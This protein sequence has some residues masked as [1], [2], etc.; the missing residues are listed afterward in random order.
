M[1]PATCEN[2][3]SIIPSLTAD[4]QLNQSTVS[5]TRSAFN[6]KAVVVGLYGVPG[7]G[8]TFLLNRLKRELGQEH[9]AFYEG[10]E[11]IATVIPGGLDEFQKLDEQEKVYWRQ[12]AIDTIGKKCADSGQ[13]AVVTGHFMFWPEEEEAGWPVYTQNDLQTYTNILYLD[14]PAEVV[15]QR[16]LEDTEKIR[17]STSVTHL[18][19]WQQAE[20]TQL[21]RL[22]REYDILFSLVSPHMLLNKVS[23]LL[24]DFRHH[25]EEY[26]LSQ[27]ESKLDEAIIADQGQ[28][29]TMLVIDADRT[30]AAEDSGALF[31][32]EVSNLRRSRDDECTLKTLF[33][34]PL[35]YSYTAFRQATLL[36]EE[37]A[38][39]QEFDALCQNVASAVTMHPEFVSLL[40]LVAEQEHVGAVVVSCGLRR[41]WEKVLEREGLSKTVK[42]VG[43]GRIADGFVVTAAVKAALV[44][45]SRDTHKMYVWAF[46]DSPLDLDMLSKA[47]EA[48]VV[49]GEEQTRSKTMDAALMNAIDN[50]GLRAC[51][52]VLPSNASPRLNTTKLPLIQLTE[53]EFVDSVLC[54][55]YRHASLQVL[56]ATDKP[57]AKL[58]MTP[59]RDATVVG[60]PL[61][62][63][64][65]RVGFYLATELL[66]GAIGV[67]EYTIPHVQGHDTGG[68]RL[69]HEQQTSIVAL[70]RGGEA[71]ALGVYEAFQRAMFVHATLPK[72][73]MLHHLQGQLTVL[74]VDSVVNSG[75]TVVEFV[76]H[77]RNL[78]ATIRIVVVTGVA[79][80]QSVSRGSLAQALAGH[81]NLSLV[82]LRISDNKFT[83]RGTTDTGN[84]LFNTTHLP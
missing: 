47:D 44:A 26:N 35:G 59:M 5:K 62:N 16:H 20:K 30:L 14:V 27:A 39:D 22:C 46:G 43:G 29:E 49:V 18:C 65:K 76:Q 78:H 7:S 74:L 25:T 50:N 19:K 60:P 3:S 48:I 70:M 11:M 52:A 28:L 57:A 73:I 32:K 61:L 53:N 24:C 68:Y 80:A 8:K 55:R 21:R 6:D 84:R 54:R 34:G 12:L 83:G 13:V 36:Y 4:P 67:E 23:T 75:K 63:A 37:T 42:V 82:A 1:L 64:H 15:A 41:V 71:M 10:S 45:R 51:Q 9:F 58:L 40:Q 17:P 79:Q 31:W 33:G 56:H 77:I 72:D 2:A 38:D 66:A 81:S 69:F